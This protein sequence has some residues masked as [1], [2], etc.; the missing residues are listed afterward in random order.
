MAVVMQV[1][2]ILALFV[3]SAHLALRGRAADAAARAN[4]RA[5]IPAAEAFALENTGSGGDADGKKATAGYKGMTAALLRANY[6]A[7]ISA[8][9]SVVSGKTNETAFCLTETIDGKTWS[10]HGPG[11][12]SSSF[13]KNAKC[14]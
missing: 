8:T 9:L 13:K 5:A 2:A 7:T 12:S 6:D 14:K 3:G 1:I 4:I 10:A 11:V